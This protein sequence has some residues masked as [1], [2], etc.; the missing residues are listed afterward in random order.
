MAREAILEYRS[1]IFRGGIGEL[2]GGRLARAGEDAKA[3][4]MDIHAAAA[5]ETGL[6]QAWM[7]K[8]MPVPPD[9]MAR[10]SQEILDRLFGR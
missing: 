9:I 4:E 6:I 2:Y 5:A 10:K 3:A 7:R 8:G 1:E